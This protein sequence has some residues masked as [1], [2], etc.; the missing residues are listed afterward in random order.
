MIL[1]ARFQRI[2]EGQSRHLASDSLNT[3]A[4]SVFRKSIE[5]GHRFVSCTYSKDLEMVFALQ[6]NDNLQAWTLPK[7]HL[8]VSIDII[9]TSIHD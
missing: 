2:I 4:R 1:T 3:V 8:H 5:T 9:N 7:D 6:D